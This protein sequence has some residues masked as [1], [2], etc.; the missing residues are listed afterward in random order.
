MSEMSNKD[1]RKSQN[2]SFV[3]TIKQLSADFGYNLKVSEWG[4]NSCDVAQ[5]APD[6]QEEEHDE[7]QH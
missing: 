7:V 6:S 2:I 1:E 4:H 5:H 3:L